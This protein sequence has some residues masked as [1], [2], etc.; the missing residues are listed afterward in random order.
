M[1][2]RSRPAVNLLSLVVNAS[3]SVGNHLGTAWH[4]D[5][6]PVF[7]SMLGYL[8]ALL[9]LPSSWARQRAW[10]QPSLVAAAT[11][12]PATAFLALPKNVAVSQQ[13]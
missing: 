13:M 1:R 6:V 5:R 9:L 11:I 12:L 2:F 8:S 7:L 4:V 10:L 3:S